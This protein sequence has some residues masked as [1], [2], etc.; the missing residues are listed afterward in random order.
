MKQ[1]WDRLFHYRYDIYFWMI[2]FVFGYYLKIDAV[3]H[4]MNLNFVIVADYLVNLFDYTWFLLL[5]KGYVYYMERSK[6]FS[7][8]NFD[9]FQELDA[10]VYVLYTFH[11]WYRSFYLR[12]HIHGISIPVHWPMMMCV[13]NFAYQKDLNEHMKLIL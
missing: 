2:V 12:N 11:I 8:C 7:V 13:R 10:L 1:Q 3:H 9:V 4:P 6:G 5:E